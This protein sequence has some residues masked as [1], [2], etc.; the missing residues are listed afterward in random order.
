MASTAHGLE[1]RAPSSS[2]QPAPPPAPGEVILRAVADTWVQIKSTKTGK[3]LFSRVLRV[4]ET[5]PAPD[6]QGL[7]M[8]VGNAGGLEILVDGTIAPSLGAHGEVV[9]DVDLSGPGLL[10]H[11]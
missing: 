10:A 9:R 11:N 1:F 7:R 2:N 4:G 6:R 5:Y 8:T 3:V